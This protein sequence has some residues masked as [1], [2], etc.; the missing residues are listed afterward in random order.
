MIHIGYYIA[1]VG[2]YK[3]GDL[4]LTYPLMRGFAPLLVALSSAAWLGEVPT[5]LARGPASSASASACALVGLAHPG[6]RCTTARR[7]RSRS[8]TR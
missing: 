2:A 6:T 4:G 8:P 7:W 5:P 3:H 1:L